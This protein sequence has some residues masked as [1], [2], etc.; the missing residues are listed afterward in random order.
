MRTKTAKDSSLSFSRQ[1]QGSRKG[2][3]NMGDRI[4]ADL[5]AIATA[6]V[7]LA[8]IAVLVSKQP[9]IITPSKPRT[10]LFSF[11]SQFFWEQPNQYHNSPSFVTMNPLRNNCQQNSITSQPHQ[12]REHIGQGKRRNSEDSLHRIIKGG[13]EPQFRPGWTQQLWR[14]HFVKALTP[15]RWVAHRF[16][17]AIA[18]HGREQTP[19]ATGRSEA[20]TTELQS[21]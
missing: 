20:H 8:I 1:L 3:S 21:L 19:V 9:D 5:V 10:S 12:L 7:S 14:G 13:G 4:I 17:R 15:G 16:C 2:R 18:E 6:I 11:I